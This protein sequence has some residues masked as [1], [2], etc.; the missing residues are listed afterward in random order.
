MTV[1]QV[2]EY[3][4]I[5]YFGFAIMLMYVSEIHECSEEVKATIKKND[6]KSGHPPACQMGNLIPS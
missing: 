4:S 3:L 6:C 2:T 5:V 1:Q